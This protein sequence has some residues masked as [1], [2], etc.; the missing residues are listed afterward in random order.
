MRHGCAGTKRL[1]GQV[2]PRRVAAPWATG[3]EKGAEPKITVCITHYNRPAYL[4]QALRSMVDQERAPF[5][6][7]VVDDGSPGEEVST[8]LAEIESQ[9]DFPARGWRLIRQENRYLGAARNRAA[10]EAG[11]DYLLFMDDDNVAKPHE[12]AWFAATARHTGADLITCLAD[13]FDGSYDPRFHDGPSS[14]WLFAGPTP[15]LSVVTNTF[16]DANAL[17]RRAA[18][19]EIGGFTEDRGVGHEDWELF[20]RFLTRGYHITVIPEALFWYRR[21]RTGMIGSTSRRANFARVLRPHLNKIP[22]VYHPLMELIIGRLAEDKPILPLR[23]QLVDSLNARMKRFPMIHWL[24]KQS[25]SVAVGT[26]RA[27]TARLHV[28]MRQLWTS[29]KKPEIGLKSNLTTRLDQATPA[30]PASH[31]RPTVAKT[32]ALSIASKD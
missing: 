4:R 7:I 20:A 22:V 16:G 24:L 23:Y 11:G 25:A 27:L 1:R 26:A 28:A 21:S 29:E 13:V 2:Q 19:L 18:F 8:E 17:I 15:T 10:A 6:V 31:G 32:R 30:L 3:T 5:E 9:F 12:M 14:I